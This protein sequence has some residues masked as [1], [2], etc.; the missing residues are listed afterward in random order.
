M[1][2]NLVYF[3]VNDAILRVYSGWTRVWQFDSVKHDALVLEHMLINRRIQTEHAALEFLNNS[4]RRH[5]FD[6][7]ASV[8]IDPNIIYSC[9]GSVHFT[10]G[11]RGWPTFWHGDSQTGQCCWAGV[12]LADFTELDVTGVDESE[13]IHVCSN[14]I[15]FQPIF[16]SHCLTNHIR[17]LFY[18]SHKVFRIVITIDNRMSDS[19]WFFKIAHHH[20]IV[21]SNWLI[22]N[23]ILNLIVQTIK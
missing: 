9:Q 22:F 23:P 18:L 10:R 16:H 15:Q 1:R 2:W 20:S 21:C 11:H 5:R 3:S 19:I 6:V 8:W 13:T 14:T 17:F 7:G 12:P 4:G